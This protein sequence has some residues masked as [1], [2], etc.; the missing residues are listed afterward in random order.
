M[1]LFGVAPGVAQDLF[2]GP[3]GGGGGDGA[4][5]AGGEGHSG[6]V[7]H[8]PLNFLQLG[9]QNG[10]GV[11]V[12]GGAGEELV[13]ILAGV[14]RDEVHGV[15]GVGKLGTCGLADASQ[16]HSQADR[17]R[18][19]YLGSAAA[20]LATQLVVVGDLLLRIAEHAAE[21]VFGGE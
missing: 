8:Q 9:C 10:V 7:F 2:D 4:R 19:G 11:H 18:S 3:D 1:Q 5:N 15:F 14:V 6:E 20:N 12:E 17:E 13:I 16:A 21:R